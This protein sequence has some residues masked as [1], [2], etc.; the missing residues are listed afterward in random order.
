MAS[1][2]SGWWQS[3]VGRDG[4]PGADVEE[5]GDGFDAGVVDKAA[6]ARANVVALARGGLDGV[7]R[8]QARHAEQRLAEA[9]L[10]DALVV[11]ED[12]RLAFAGVDVEIEQQ[13]AAVMGRKA[14]EPVGGRLR[15]A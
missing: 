8:Q 10:D 15:I 4:R 5:V 13:A 7:R 2:R 9:I 12:Q 14:L 6:G 1:S 3:T 11:R